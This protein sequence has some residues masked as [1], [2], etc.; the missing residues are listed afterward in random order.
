MIGESMT[1]KWR[2]FNELIDCGFPNHCFQSCF[3]AASTAWC[4]MVNQF[5]WW[6][7]PIQWRQ[8][9]MSAMASQITSLA[10]VYSTIYSDADLGKHQSSASLAFPAQ[11]A[12]NAEYVS[13]WWRHHALQHSEINSIY[14][15]YHFVTIT[16]SRFGSNNHVDC[17]TR[18]LIVCRY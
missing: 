14:A 5:L 2:T 10:I 4:K 3:A 6:D 13:I 9:E 11:R 1:L 18:L 16:I 7:I 17:H 15:W 12:S 8:N